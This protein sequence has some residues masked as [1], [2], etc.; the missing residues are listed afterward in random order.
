MPAKNNR[1]VHNY[2]EE[3]TLKDILEI[4]PWQRI[5]DSFSAVTDV[6]IRI[7]DPDGAA[8]T[9]SGKGPRLCQQLLKDS[10]VRAI[11]CGPCLPT[12]LHGKA[13]VD[14]NLSFSCSAGLYNFIAPL[15]VEK[16]KILGYLIIGPM[17]LVMRRT[18]EEYRRIAA[19]LGLE[20]EDFWS[21]LLEIKI[22]SFH[23][24]QSLVELIKNVA[25]YTLRLSYRSAIKE[26]RAGPSVVSTGK[27]AKLMDALLDVAFEI[28]KADV[29]SVMFLNKDRDELTIT[30]SRGISKDIAR[31]ARVKLGRGVSGI[32]AK[33]GEAFLI[34]NAAPDN[35]IAP[36]LKKPQIGSSM[37]IPLKVE[38]E[39]VGVMNVG[40]LNTSAI[41]FTQDNLCQMKKLAGLAT[42]GITQL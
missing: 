27:L 22:I 36:Y 26:R 40:A 14:K 18:K 31:K 32:A 41:R 1:R 30:A 28:S 8:V 7:V 9:S 16:E 5:Q 11:I 24:A 34:D 42:V 29:G 3:L 37:V 38:K 35:R 21:A 15:A 33:E 6:N 13:V 2:R 12:F 19:E 20:L 25:E 4:K 23:S 10:P 39:I 17:V